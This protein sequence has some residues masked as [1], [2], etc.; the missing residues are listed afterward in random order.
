MFDFSLMKK[1]VESVQKQHDDLCAEVQTVEAKIIQTRQAPMNKADFSEMVEL[2]V[3]KSA[4]GFAPAVA[5][6]MA[7]HHRTGVAGAADI[8]FFSLAT[9]AAGD[10]PVSAMDGVMCAVFGDQIK[11]AIVSAID[12]M[13]WPGEGLPK[14]KRDAEVNRLEALAQ[15][16]RRQLDSITQ[17]AHEAG[18][19]I[20]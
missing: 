9:N 5:A 1:S 20:K 11:K 18:I 12:G 10:L 4:A 14:A 8:G 17:G 13:D 7:R 19:A 2:W 6:H 15:D 16:L 3:R